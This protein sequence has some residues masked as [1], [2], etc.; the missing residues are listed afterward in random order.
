MNYGFERILHGEQYTEVV[1]P[2]PSAAKLVHKSRIKDIWDKGKNALVVSETKS[3]DEKGDLLMI[4]EITTLVRGAG[5]WGGDRGPTDPVNVPPSRAADATITEKTHENQALL[6]RLN[7]DFNPLHVDP[8]FAT[9]M[10]FQKPILHGLCTFGFAARHVIK[11]FAKNGDP[12]YFKS[13]KVRFADSVFPGETLQT[14]MWKESDT[15]IVFTVKAVERNAVVVS[16]AAIEFYAEIPKP[17]AKKAA[18]AAAP[19][20]S[21]ASAEPTTADVFTGMGKYLEANPKLASQIQT[22]YQ[23]KLTGPDSAYFLNLKDGNGSLTAGE[24]KADCT[25]ELSDADFMAMA[26]GKADPQKLYFGGKMKITG[27]VMASQKLTFLQKIDP[28]VVLDAAKARAAGGGGAAAPAAAAAAAEGPNVGAIFWGI[29]W[30]IEQHPELATS[31]QGIFQFKLL[32]PDAAYVLDLK[33]GKGSAKEG[34]VDKA[35]V[36]LEL[37]TEDFVG[38]ASGKLDAN[39]LYFGGKLKITGNVMA[40]QKLNFLSKI[41]QGQVQAAYAKAHGGAAPAAAAPAAAAPKAAAPASTAEPK[42][43]AIFAAVTDRFA[44]N[45]GLAAEVGALLQFKVKS[46]DSQWVVDLRSGATIKEGTDA[47]ATTTLTLADE[48]LAALAGGAPAR[49]LFQHGKLR[50]DGDIRLAHKLAFLKGLFSLSRTTQ[51]DTQHGT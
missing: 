48:D 27:N 36:V 45:P 7:G 8:N 11:S 40:S 41:D 12:R 38:M 5:G 30:Y 19:A 50:V 14:E 28:Q 33:N 44:K 13:I 1:R 20:A 46:P 34:T 16:N 43:K 24:Q 21:A 32:G 29:N 22:T 4:N 42:A 2:L 6:Y 10:G 37:S 25:L 49:D 35:D 9:A 3:Y 17:A 26:G 31:I 39:K 18:A 23:F 15:K 47:A 51:G